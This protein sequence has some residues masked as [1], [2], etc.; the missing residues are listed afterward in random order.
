MNI[1]TKV[2]P[3]S[4]ATSLERV[5]TGVS[6]GWNVEHTAEGTHAWHWTRPTFSATR[7]MGVGTIT[8]TVGAEDVVSERYGRLGSTVLY[9]LV[10]NDTS[11]SGAGATELRV[12]LPDRLVSA[13]Y[14]AVRCAY[15]VDNGTVAEARVFARPGTAFLSIYRNDGANWSAAS[16]NATTVYFQM[17]L[18]VQ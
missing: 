6:A 7:F 12:L 11:T 14:A 4:L 8:W 9:N 1:P 15:A 10:L 2:S 18:E 5:A 3:M 17:G 13:S 16:A